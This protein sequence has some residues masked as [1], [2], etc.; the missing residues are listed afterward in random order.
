VHKM[1]KFG[2]SPQDPIGLVRPGV[3]RIVQL[4]HEF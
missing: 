4:L 1:H 3:L 2:D